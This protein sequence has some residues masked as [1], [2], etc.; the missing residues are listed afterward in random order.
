MFDLMDIQGEV[1][2]GEGIK[3]NAPGIFKG[4]H[5]GTWKTLVPCAKD[6]RAVV[7]YLRSS[8]PT[9]LVQLDPDEKLRDAA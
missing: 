3:D 5:L 9:F 2:I 7:E 1:V 6:E 4:E 8:R